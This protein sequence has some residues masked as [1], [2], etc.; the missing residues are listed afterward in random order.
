[1]HIIGWSKDGMVSRPATKEDIERLHYSRMRP[2]YDSVSG[3][4]SSNHKEEFALFNRISE[5]IQAGTPQ[6]AIDA[7]PA[8]L[9]MLYDTNGRFFVGNYGVFRRIDEIE[10]AL[11]GDYG[12]DRE[13]LKDEDIIP[14]ENSAFDIMR[15][16]QQRLADVITNNYETQIAIADESGDNVLKDILIEQCA[17]ELLNIPSENAMMFSINSAFCNIGYTGPKEVVETVDKSFYSDMS[18]AAQERKERFEELFLELS[19]CRKK[20]QIYGIPVEEDGKTNWKGGF[21]N[22]IREFYFRDKNIVIAWSDEKKAEARRAFIKQFRAS[23]N[24]MHCEETLRQELYWRFDRVSEIK[25]PE[26]L[27]DEFGKKILDKDKKVT[28][29]SKWDNDRSKAFLEMS[30]TMGQW[31]A[32][33]QL[34]DLLIHRIDLNYN[35]DKDRNIA[36]AILREEFDKI[37]TCDDLAEHIKMANKRDWEYEISVERTYD[38]VITTPKGEKKLFNRK[39]FSKRDTHVFKPSLIDRISTADEFRWKRSVRTL[40]KELTPVIVINKQ[41]K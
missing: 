41:E 40:A 12:S 34:K 7:L 27:V 10:Q 18:E 23:D 24:P 29:P 25:Y 17:A 20:T 32:I 9:R 13:D 16:E 6:D 3:F 22:K 21:L 33:Y 19:L 31:K 4:V 5:N 28:K 30:M 26:F 37:E 2:S 38:D 1:M 39:N 36:I 15:K 14:D 35:E 11:D 8:N